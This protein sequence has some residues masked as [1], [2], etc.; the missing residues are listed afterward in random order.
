MS[1]PVIIPVGD[2][3]ACPFCGEQ[4]TGSPCTSCGRDVTAARRVCPRCH[5]MTPAL[6]KACSHCGAEHK[7]DLRWKV[8]LIIAIFVVAFILAVLL[9]LAR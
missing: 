3:R 8:P 7:S 4:T 1:D 2:V 6:E 5:K 9:Q